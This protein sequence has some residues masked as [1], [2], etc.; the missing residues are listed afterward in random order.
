MAFEKR[1]LRL[2][3]NSEVQSLISAMPVAF[4]T[5]LIRRY[6]A[7]VRPDRYYA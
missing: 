3:P 4:M 2:T 5:V 6:S 1:P 7:F